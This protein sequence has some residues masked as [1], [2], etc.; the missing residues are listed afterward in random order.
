MA[1]HTGET[2]TLTCHGC[3]DRFLWVVKRAR[4]PKWCSERCRRNQYDKQ[5]LYCGVRVSGTDPGR[6]L[7]R[8]TKCARARYSKQVRE[9]HIA[10]IRRWVAVHGEPPSYR[11][12]EPYGCR[13]VLHDEARAR[14]AEASLV[15]GWPSA[16]AVINA[17]GSWNA[18]IRAAG[19]EPRAPHGGAGNQQ[20]RRRARLREISDAPEGC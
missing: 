4:V 18:A 1:R 2:V 11:D 10:M 17:W 12:W 19:F 14:R 8:C 7:G 20:R 15:E 3:G 9:G 16:G 13:Q 6:S 5:C